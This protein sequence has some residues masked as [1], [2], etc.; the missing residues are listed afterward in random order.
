MDSRGRLAVSYLAAF[1][2][3]RCGPWVCTDEPEETPALR[4]LT[5]EACVW[6]VCKHAA[7]AATRLSPRQV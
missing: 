3:L 6:G 1:E 2:P 4:E 7:S 5:P